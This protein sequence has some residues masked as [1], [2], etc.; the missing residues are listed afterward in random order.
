MRAT[1]AFMLAIFSV[2]FAC[3]G[4]DNTEKNYPVIGASS[5]SAK[6]KMLLDILKRHR[7]PP[8][9]TGACIARVIP[10]GPAYTAGIESMDVVFKIDA[11]PISTPQG[12]TDAVRDLRVGKKSKFYLRRYVSEKN[13][14]KWEIKII[15]V[16]PITKSEL[17]KIVK[18]TPPVDILGVALKHNI[19]NQP[20]VGVLLR[21]QS[22]SQVVALK[23]I[24]KCWDRFDDEARGF[25]ST[26]EFR[27]IGQSKIDPGEKEIFTWQLSGHSNAARIS[28]S[29]G[30][31]RLADGTEWKPG[32]KGKQPMG[33]AELKD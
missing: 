29:L 27:G 31:V 11:K 10:Y 21:N 3:A 16:T 15:S 14:S 22:Q 28:V 20:E 6:D 30:D 32:G 18:E 9:K 7:I 17:D 25:G 19:I 12:F 4:Q 5:A 33:T 26:N 2:P 24:V 13:S 8:P 23:I 1:T